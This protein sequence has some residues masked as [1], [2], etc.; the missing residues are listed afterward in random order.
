MINKIKIKKVDIFDIKNF[1]WRKFL[2]YEIKVKKI[3]TEKNKINGP[4]VCFICPPSD[5]PRAYIYVKKLR[6]LKKIIIILKL[7]LYF[8]LFLKIK[9]K[10]I[11][12]DKVIKRSDFVAL[13]ELGI[14]LKGC[15]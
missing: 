14:S 15:G 2:K 6:K 13:V 4:V 7:L 8:S 9:L 3:I 10:L 12:K 5:L 1:F 11:I